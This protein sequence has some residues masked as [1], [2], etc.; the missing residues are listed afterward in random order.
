MNKIVHITPHFAVTG[1]LRPDFAQA[2]AL[3]FKSIVSN[4]P[5]GEVAVHLQA[6]R[7]RS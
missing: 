3:G 7:R 2:A 4:L 5:D 6:G 1:A